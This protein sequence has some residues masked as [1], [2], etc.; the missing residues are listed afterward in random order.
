MSESTG[1]TNPSDAAKTSRVFLLVLDDTDELTV[2]LG[3]ACQR[4]RKSGGRV[5]LLYV[6][7][8]DEFQQWM[9][10][11]DLM[12]E[13]KRQE[14]EQRLQRYARRVFDRTGTFPI[15]F[16]RE[17]QRREELLKLIE[18]EPSVSVLVLGAGTGPE[19]PGPL[20]SHLTGKGLGRLRVPLTIVP[21]NLT[22]EQLDA[23]T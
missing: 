6:M 18:E 22:E 10:V 13:E 7:E 12:R 2:A 15:L 5:A 3:Y 21:G 9:M 8:P 14:A 1:D 19:G 20:V 4:A 11:Q 23:I 17:G 16:L